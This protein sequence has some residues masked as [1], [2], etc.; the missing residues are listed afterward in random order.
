[1]EGTTWAWPICRCFQGTSPSP[2]HLKIK[3]IE[4]STQEVGYH[5]VLSD[6]KAF[7]FKVGN[8]AV[9]TKTERIAL[10]TVSKKD[11]P[12]PHIIH[13]FDC[14][15]HHNEEEHVTRTFVKMQLCDGTLK[16]YLDQTKK[17]GC[18]IE[19]LEVVEIMI[20]ILSGLC[21]CHERS[22]CHRDLTLSN[23]MT[24]YR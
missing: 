11:S 13:V 7:A 10:K 2:S 1:M 18:T 19:P 3:A 14:W 15:F 4:K 17:S 23:S 8:N 20:Q 12:N 24:L 5:P 9:D 22:I 16:Q 6:F 21:L